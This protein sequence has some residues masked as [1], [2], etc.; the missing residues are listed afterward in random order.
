M[1]KDSE[2]AWNDFWAQQEKNGGGGCLPD[3]WS[4]IDA[5]QQGAWNE[6][7][8]H[9]P[10]PCRLLDLATGD[11]RVMQWL[12]RSR[13]DLKLVGVDLAPTLPAPPRGAKVK[14]GVAMEHLPFPDARFDAIT[15]QFGFEYGQVEQVAREIARVLSPRG[16]AGLMTH[17]IDG[18]ILAHNHR[19]RAQIEWALHEQGLI[20]IAKQSLRLRGNGVAIIPVQIMQAVAEGARRFG[21]Q[22]AAWEIPE[23]IRR[24]LVLGARDHPANV[25]ATLDAIT[26]RAANEIGRIRSLAD[27]CSTA[28]DVQRLA[29]A[30]DAAGLKAIAVTPLV[31]GESKQPFADFRLLHR[32][33]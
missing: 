2:R 6:F 28:A 8:R 16:I 11:G 25:A 31:E 13:R 32:K 12:M 20:A 17:R 5:V 21:P 10:R 14:T 19:R 7:A 24:T 23:A 33:N 15:S 29:Q 4:G 26:D 22:S 18:P 27:A 1:S 9:L 3:G 30:F